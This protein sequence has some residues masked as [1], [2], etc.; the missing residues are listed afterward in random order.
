MK[1]DD[2]GEFAGNDTTIDDKSKEDAAQKEDTADEES[3]KGDGNLEENQFTGGSE[4]G[5][6]KESQLDQKLDDASKSENVNS[7]TTLNASEEGKLDLIQPASDDAQGRRED[8]T[9]KDAEDEAECAERGETV[10]VKGESVDDVETNVTEKAEVGES[11]KN[12]LERVE[13]GGIER[14]DSKGT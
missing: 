11:E 10:E 7:D 1:E 5:T 12:Q 13:D 4:N 14:T 2:V 3:A 6:D 9:M 8:G